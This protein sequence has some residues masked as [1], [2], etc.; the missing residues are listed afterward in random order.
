MN[1]K[2]SVSDLIG[3]QFGSNVKYTLILED[4]RTQIN[5]SQYSATIDLTHL[6]DFF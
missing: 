3:S 4:A 1:V 6:D 2:D 5:Y